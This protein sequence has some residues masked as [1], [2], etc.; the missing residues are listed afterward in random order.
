MNMLDRDGSDASG[1]L[2]IGGPGVWSIEG[3]NVHDELGNSRQ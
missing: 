1:D 2:R 3:T